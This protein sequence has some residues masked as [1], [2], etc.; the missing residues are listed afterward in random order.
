MYGVRR[1]CASCGSGGGNNNFVSRNWVNNNINNY[2]PSSS[3]YNFNNN[4]Y[5][6]PIRSTSNYSY[7][8]NISYN[9]RPFTSYQ[10]R[11]STGNNYINYRNNN[12]QRNENLYSPYRSTSQYNIRPMSGLYDNYSR[13]IQNYNYYNLSMNGSNNEGNCPHCGQNH[14]RYR[15]ISA[16]SNPLRNS[17]MN[18]NYNNNY[19]INNFSLST[20]NY[21]YSNNNNNKNNNNYFGNAFTPQRNNNNNNLNSYS[22]N[23]FNSAQVPNKT[24]SNFKMTNNFS[25]NNYANI[26]NLNNRNNSYNN[27]NNF[28]NS[29]NNN[30]NNLNN[31]NVLNS[32]N[33]ITL[34]YYDFSNGIRQLIEQRKSFFLLMFGTFDYR[35]VSWCSDCNF[36]EPLIKKAKNI[37][38][39][40]Q[41]QKPILWVNVPI[42]KDKRQAYKFDSYLRMMYVPTLIYFE[43]GI[44]MRRIVQ[45][46]LFTQENI[47][48]FI[49]RAYQ[50]SYY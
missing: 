6:S 19:N 28:S 42:E 34:G 9:Q 24:F 44:E 7:N 2:S 5:S 13:D 47:N 32:S 49:L 48:N 37:V 43:N 17:H 20:S 40:K 14:S 41:S 38:F 12:F 8:Q 33:E 35:G 45:E 21:N 29:F 23:K 31:R 50:Q 3:L 18:T 16:E 36:T 1:P 46:Q 15:N 10:N 27:Y 26:N 25:N 22:S 4:R 30:N 11:F 39:S